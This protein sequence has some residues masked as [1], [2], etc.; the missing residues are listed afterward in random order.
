[1]DQFRTI[2]PPDLGKSGK[3]FGIVKYAPFTLIEKDSSNC[4][5][6]MLF[7]GTKLSHASVDEKRIDPPISFIHLGHQLFNICE[8]LRRP[9]LRLMGVQHPAVPRSRLYADLP[10]V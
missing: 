7:K 1:M 3:A 10:I 9:A 4:A 5:S 6:A 8:A 2:V